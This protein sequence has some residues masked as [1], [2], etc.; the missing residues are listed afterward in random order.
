MPN[1]ELILWLLLL[2]AVFA[3]IARGLVV[4]YPV[5]LVLGGL[6]IGLVPGL[7]QVSLDPDVVFLLFLPPIL[8]QAA[9][10][11]SLRDFRENIR[12][13]SALAVGLV[14]VTGLAV[15]VTAREL[16]P[17]LPWSVALVLGAVVSPPDAVAAMAVLSRL[18]VP[19]RVVTIL[20]GESLVND[21]TA[22]VLY[23]FAVAAVLTGT[24]AWES[25]PGTFALVAAGGIGIGLVIG[26][27]SLRAHRLVQEVEIGILLSL[28]VPFAAYMTAEAVHVS[29]VLSAVCAGLVRGWYLPEQFSARMRVQ[30][31]AVWRMLIYLIN[32]VVFIL[33]GFELS[34]AVERLTGFET[35]GNFTIAGLLG[36]A[37]VI[38]AVAI[39]VR[40]V[41]VFGLD[42]LGRLVRRL[43]G[44]TQPG[45]PWQQTAIIAWC[46]LR[47]IVS[48][49]AALA[50][51]LTTAEGSAFPGREFVIL[52]AFAVVFATL[53]V[54]G[55]SLTYLIRALRVG[56]DSKVER[57]ERIARLKATFAGMAEIE[58]LGTAGT[59]PAESV[60][61]IRG[62]YKRR[63]M[64][65]RTFARARDSAVAAAIGREWLQLRQA[66]L[67][68][69]RRRLL[70]LRRDRI[71]G[72]EALRRIQLELDIEELRLR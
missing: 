59:Y 12:P 19:R 26:W 1:I 71:I 21:A 48:L 72:D 68:A 8:Y 57:E 40:I 67:A 6:A 64:E 55:T 14:L 34:R 36:D 7:P 60:A 31:Q 15:A 63:L 33:I 25:F 29:G 44:A 2:T 9:I 70:K 69:E 46:G 35:P 58:R 39:G 28:M 24:F 45:P 30:A 51:P 56:V 37:V 43:R 3:S 11:T 20:E 42:G 50:L 4:P 27:L 38:S 32:G 52:M 54:Q 13:I 66:A 65:L 17:G 22:L 62:E 53:V 18:K 23:R 61:T 41:W 47:G 5:V 10:F 16:F 49:A